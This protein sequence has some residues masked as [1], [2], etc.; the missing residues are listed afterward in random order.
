MRENTPKW[1]AALCSKLISLLEANTFNII[2]GKPSLEIKVISSRLPEAY[3]DLAKLTWLSREPGHCPG[4]RL[5]DKRPEGHVTC[6]VVGAGGGS[7]THS[8]C[9]VSGVRGTTPT[10]HIRVY[11]QS[12][13]P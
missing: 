11:S 7:Y 3:T 8:T 10:T 6:G 12:D 9:V 4:S 5:S 13:F 2:K 1:E